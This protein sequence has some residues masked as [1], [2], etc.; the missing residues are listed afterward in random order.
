MVVL[1]SR[2]WQFVLAG[3]LSAC[4][5]QAAAATDLATDLNAFQVTPPMSQSP[6]W[7]GF[8]LRAKPSGGSDSSLWSSI[9]A[10]NALSSPSSARPADTT[11][12][13]NFQTG[14]F[15]FG[16]EGSLAAA[17]VD[18]K[19]T[20]PYLPATGAWSPNMN[21]LGTVTGRFGYSFGQWMPYVK[22]GFATAD[23]GSGL[24]DGTLAGFSQSGSQRS[25][26]TA[27]VGLEYQLSSK[28][29]LGL[30]YL[31]TDLGGGNGQN[32]IGSG[33]SPDVYGTA[34]KSQ[35]LLGR[36]NYKAGW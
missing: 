34:L 1:V 17:S 5:V 26:W 22:G 27:G 11:F 21:W 35:S 3:G 6:D 28:W 31:Y 10:S 7:A 36:L 25:G 20:A 16:V 8:Y 14:N 30:E 9:G 23:V 12:G 2:A 33:G 24:Q 19:F 15:V 32:G 13:Y 18:G 29:S 4:L